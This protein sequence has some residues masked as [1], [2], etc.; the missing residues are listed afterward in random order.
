MKTFFQMITINIILWSAKWQTMG[1]QNLIYLR[2]VINPY[3]DNLRS[4]VAIIATVVG[5]INNMIMIALWCIATNTL[6]TPFS[7][8]ISNNLGHCCFF[9]ANNIKHNLRT[10]K[11]SDVSR[12]GKENWEGVLVN[13]GEYKRATDWNQ[14]RALFTTF[15][16]IIYNFGWNPTHLRNSWSSIRMR[17]CDQWI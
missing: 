2:A 3:L 12:D 9:M 7:R 1:W 17:K 8:R 5:M 10:L 6:E 4:P 16:P 14:I 13:G 11:S 15:T